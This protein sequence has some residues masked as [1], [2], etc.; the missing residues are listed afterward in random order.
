VRQ[1]ARWSWPRPPLMNLPASSGDRYEPFIENEPTKSP[2]G[3]TYPRSG[4]RTY[5]PQ[6]RVLLSILG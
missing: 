4:S 5:A 6:G 2:R 1:L 3:R